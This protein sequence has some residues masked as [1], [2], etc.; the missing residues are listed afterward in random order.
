MTISDVTVTYNNLIG[1]KKTI[2]SLLRQ[3]VSNDVKLQ[4][5]VIDGGSSDG[6]REFLEELSG[7][8]ENK[9]IDFS[10][11]SEPDSGIY[12]AMNKGIEMAIGERIFF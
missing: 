5:I 4:V 8:I 3:T 1:L 9:N 11:V 6:S 12:N 2:E 7:K 10:Y